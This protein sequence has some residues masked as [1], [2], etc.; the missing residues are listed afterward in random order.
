MESSSLTLAHSH[1]RNALLETRKSNP[2]AASEEHDLAAGEF[3][4]AAQGTLDKNALRTLYLLEQHHKRLAKIIK[5]QHE[6]PR[7][8]SSPEPVAIIPNTA[9]A[10]TAAVAPNTPLKSA[11]S[12]AISPAQPLPKPPRLQTTHTSGQRETTSLASN[13]ASARGI[14]RGVPSV[15][16]VQNGGTHRTEPPNR[17]KVVGALV[18]D[19][20]SGYTPGWKP[21]WSPA[22]SPTEI[23][24]QRGIGKDVSMAI[25]AVSGD[26]PFRKFYSTFGGLI[27]RL[28]APL[29]FASL[30]LGTD[31]SGEVSPTSSKAPADTKVDK[32]SAAADFT[33]YSRKEPDVK[34]LVSSAAL[35][36][37]RD[38]DGYLTSN[39]SESFY[40]VPTSSGMISYA[41]ILSRAEKEALKNSIEEDEDTF[42]D[43]SENPPSPE[44]RGSSVKDKSKGIKR[45]G[46]FSLQASPSTATFNNI[47]TLEELQMENQALKHLS[48]TLSKR[49]HMWEVSSQSSTAALQQSFI[50]L[51]NQAAVSR[52]ASPAPTSSQGPFLKPE[53]QSPYSPMSNDAETLRKLEELVK[54]HELE[55]DRVGKE[56]EKLKVLLGRYRDRW[57]KL[58]EGA[59][60]RR[61]GNGQTANPVTTH[62]GGTPGDDPGFKSAVP[63]IEP[64]GSGTL[65]ASSKS[66]A[67]EEK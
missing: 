46:R 15:P 32:Y 65:D 64:D 56:N 18:P 13:L 67:G 28:S 37:I 4:T 38:R 14:R 6:N 40:V 31:T 29:A 63:A 20:R 49:L 10:T 24:R 60:N 22:V 53:A 8:V 19:T 23:T 25:R 30:P 52:Q 59:R 55:L 12:T 39:S 26:E 50:A 17:L 57:E 16:S 61:E 2:V 44:Y 35:R 66:D 9:I 33:Q 7:T 27:S 51:Q 1:A 42:V 43:A 58:K 45:D 5:F 41:G 62:S 21:S 54:H 34:K 36:A 3:A 47:K 48:D 11:P